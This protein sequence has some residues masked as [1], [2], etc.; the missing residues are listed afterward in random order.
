MDLSGFGSVGAITNIK[1]PIM[2]AHSI[3]KAQDQG[4]L[5]MGRIV[6]WLDLFILNR[7]Y[8]KSLICSLFSMLIGEGAK[9]WAISNDLEEVDDDYHKTGNLYQEVDI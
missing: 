9:L 2:A 1:N 4:F 5:S 7:F 6:P 3:L 8:L